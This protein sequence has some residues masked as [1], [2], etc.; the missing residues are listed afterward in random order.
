MKKDAKDKNWYKEFI[1]FTKSFDENQV[2][3]AY[4]EDD[5]IPHYYDIIYLK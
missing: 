5:V 3:V 2:W 4:D 1:N